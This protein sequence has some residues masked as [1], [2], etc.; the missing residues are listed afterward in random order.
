MSEPRIMRPRRDPAMGM[1]VIS[2]V[3]SITELLAELGLDEEVVGV[4]RFCVRPQGWRARKAIVGGT[5]NVRIE[6][7][8]ALRPDLVIANREENVREQVEAL[9]AFTSVHLTDVA[10]VD[11]GL[12]MMR[13]VGQ[14]VGR[15]GAAAAL[16]GAIEAAFERLGPREPLPAAYLIWRNPYMAAGGGTFISDVMGRAG[17]RNVFA[18]SDRYPE[19]TP[20]MLAEA[21]DAAILLSSEPFP[22]RRRH[23]SELAQILPETKIELVD[24]Q[25]F[26]W[27]GSRMRHMPG[28]LSRLRAALADQPS[29]P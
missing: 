9:A 19:V 20:A 23:A 15:P 22:F 14:L 6:R 3:P 26:S 12:A 17:F 4:T 10:T 18:A 25:L 13:E 2:L 29:S 28:Y 7:V 24:G 5:K 11:D 21:G 1:R 8:E 16:A 27:Y